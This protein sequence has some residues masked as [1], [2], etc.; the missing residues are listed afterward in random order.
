MVEI[1]PNFVCFGPIETGTVHVFRR[2]VTFELGD[3]DTPARYRP[4]NETD[5]WGVGMM[6]LDQAW[7]GQRSPRAG[8][9]GIG[10]FADERLCKRCAERWPYDSVLLFE[11]ETG[12]DDADD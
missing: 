11:H 2:Y 9:F 1:E 10:A 7:C 6:A 5:H 8:T 4:V 12:A 3:D